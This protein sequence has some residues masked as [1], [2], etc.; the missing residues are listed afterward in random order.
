M[1]TPTWLRTETWTH[2][3]KNTALSFYHRHSGGKVRVCAQVPEFRGHPWGDDH[4]ADLQSQYQD[5]HLSSNAR[6][7]TFDMIKIP[8]VE[9]LSTKLQEIVSFIS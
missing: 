8:K 7:I 2:H 5:F 6:I 1:G 9:I 4:R 3:P